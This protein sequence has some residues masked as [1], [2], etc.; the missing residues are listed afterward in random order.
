MPER[1][2]LHFDDLLKVVAFVARVDEN[3]RLLR[4]SPSIARRIPDWSKRHLDTMIECE[5]CGKPSLESLRSTQGLIHRVSLL[6]S[7]EPLAL[8]GRWLGCED[9]FVFLGNPDVQGAEDMAYYELE[10]FAD[11][12]RSIELMV[13]R[14]ET[15]ASL[16]EASSA[17]NLLNLRNKELEAS[18]HAVDE[19]VV[20]LDRQRRASLNLMRDA[21][22]SRRQAEQNAKKLGLLAKELGIKNDELDQARLDAERATAAKSTFLANMSH[23]VRT[24]LNGIL[25]MTGLLLDTTLEPEQFQF[26]EA[27]QSSGRALLQII[28]DILDVSKIEA[29][30]LEI[31]SVAFDLHDLLEE[32]NQVMA[33]QAE[34]KGLSYLCQIDEGVP[35]HFRGDPV[36]LRQIV[37]NL[38]GNAIKFTRSGS[39][40][41]SVSKEQETSHQIRLRFEIEDTGI[42][43]AADKVEKLFEAFTQADASTTRKY[44]GTGLGLAISRQLAGMMDGV[45]E[46]ESE[47]GRGTLFRLTLPLLKEGESEAGEVGLSGTRVLLLAEKGEKLKD[48]SRLLK[49]WDCLCHWAQTPEAGAVELVAKRETKAPHQVVLVDPVFVGEQCDE[50]GAARDGAGPEERWGMFRAISSPE[51]ECRHAGEKGMPEVLTLP[52]RR[53]QLLRFLHGQTERVRA[54]KAAK[55]AQPAPQETG[56]SLLVAEDNPTNQLVAKKLLEK[57]GYQV[58]MVSDGQEALDALR[59]GSY[60]LVLMD[61][62]MPVLNGM[63]ATQRIRAGDAGQDKAEVPILAMTAHSLGG[64]KE[65]FLA[66]G[67][68][69]YIS[70][71]IEPQ[72]LFDTL[73]RWLGSVDSVKD[74]LIAPQSVSGEIFDERSALSR[75]EGDRDL[76]MEILAVFM[77]EAPA[78]LRQ[79][80]KSAALGDLE[81]LRRQAHSLKSAAGSVAAQQL[82]ERAAR[83]ESHAQSGALDRAMV[84]VRRLDDDLDSLHGLLGEKGLLKSVESE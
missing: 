27:V 82:T 37:T 62:E 1:L 71:P 83:I 26:A 25:G 56:L 29:G 59:Q 2:T 41:L 75:V 43:I 31:E 47:E 55:V 54:Q 73:Q 70:K 67:M 32:L 28:N 4:V 61:V 66:V 19:K 17:I 80:S 48:L 13:G 40:S 78:Q 77:E 35:I 30:R 15:Q 81:V 44:G 68:N 65:R 12:D 51:E 14:E 79:I 46:V 3:L 18:R 9:G 20:E 50:V 64:H 63:E 8:R 24:P 76:L 10:D 6:I 53:E 16:E 84:E 58:T 21:D 36:R 7:P 60:D 5:I 33:V 38:L 69:D 45:I 72:A 22:W 49:A 52:L 39:V 42:G 23:E 57:H 34:L 74:M 11:G